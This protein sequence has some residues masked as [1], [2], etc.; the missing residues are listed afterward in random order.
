MSMPR[1]SS[2]PVTRLLAALALACAALALPIALAP[3][4]HAA[5]EPPSD[6]TARAEWLSTQAETAFSEKR[7]ADAIRL[8]L[9]AW[10]ASPAASI[11]YNVAFIYDKRLDDPE[12]AIDY[13]DRAARSPDADADLKA[14]ARARIATLQAQLAGNKP[15]PDKP[16]PDKPPPDKPPGPHRAG[17]AGPWILLGTGGAVLAGG[18]VM[19][20]VASSTQG[21]FDDA[22][23][24]ADKRSL[25]DQGRTEALIADLL[26]G[27]GIAAIGVGVVWAILDGGSDPG[28]ASVNP[29]GH[30]GLELTP[31]IIPGGAALVLG[32]TL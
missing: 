14:K 31:R 7:F 19:G 5:D 25:Q 28:E 21:D 12:L 6:P 27:T 4:A 23:S 24:A 3:L 26:M 32:G 1:P 15:P 13:Y 30:G 18:V 11:L 2:S 17:S 29:V 8:Y 16:P 9:D 20:L 10:E 22:E